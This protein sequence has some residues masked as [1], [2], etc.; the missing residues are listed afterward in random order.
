MP[1]EEADHGEGSSASIRFDAKAP[2]GEFPFPWF[3]LELRPSRLTSP[4]ESFAGESTAVYLRKG[5]YDIAMGAE[6]FT[7]ESCLRAE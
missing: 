2:K 5:L 4:E 3:V 6:G 1:D 7:Q